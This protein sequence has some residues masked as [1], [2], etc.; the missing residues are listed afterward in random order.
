[1]QATSSAQGIAVAVARLTHGHV[2]W[3]FE[4]AEKRDIEL[5]GIYEPDSEIADRYARKFG[6]DRRL[7]HTN[8][9]R[10]FTATRP[11]AVAA[12][13]SIAEHVAV[14]EAAAPSGIHVMVE[15]PLAF[16]LEDAARIEA[17]AKRHGIHVLTNYETTWYRSGYT[18]YE[19]VH[20]AGAIGPI[21]KLIIRDGHF[22]PKELNVPPEFLSWLT[23]PE[24]NGGGA[25][26]DFGCYG[27]NLA[28]WL[29]RG[30]LP[31]SVTAVT[32][33]LKND[34]TYARVEDEATVILTYANAQ[35]IIQGSWNWPDH[36]KDLE[37]F[38][39]HG[40]VFTPDA[41]N[42]RMRLRGEFAEKVVVPAELNS[43]HGNCFA[44]LAAVA[45]GELRVAEAD[46]SSLA[47]NLTVV[48]ILDAA[49]RSA[50]SRQTIVLED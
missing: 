48:R 36:R 34:P 15:K 49:R 11:R 46:R 39:T 23:D 29:M 17:L 40:Y 24:Q 3:V 12:F 18:A 19:L 47:N 44:Y 9:E 22:G 2:S 1:L 43:S 31:K 28:T 5:V 6:F 13:G 10:M 4:R 16:S 45:R 33:Q 14:V 35:A 21:R 25:L 26:I 50:Q 27:A 7:L 38:G 41:S 30:A 42:V 8:L 32:Q 20:S 37:I